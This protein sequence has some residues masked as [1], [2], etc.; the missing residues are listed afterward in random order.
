MRNFF[1]RQV[2]LG[3]FFLVVISLTIVFCVGFFLIEYE[4]HIV[5]RNYAYHIKESEKIQIESKII[6]DSLDKKYDDLYSS[7]DKLYELNWDNVDFW[8]DYYDIKNKEVVTSQIAVESGNLTSNFC[9]NYGNLVGMHYPYIRKTCASGS[10][11]GDGSRI[12]TYDY[13]WQSIQDYGYWQEYFDYDEDYETDVYLSMLDNHGN[14]G[15][16]TASNYAK[17][18]KNTHSMKY[19]ESNT[20]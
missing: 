2:T 10:I 11:K 20:Q 16:A 3:T 7:L 4:K 12:A 18:V 14:T 8:L 6:I 5:E 17:T 15:Y 19:P 9:V 1:S 13:W